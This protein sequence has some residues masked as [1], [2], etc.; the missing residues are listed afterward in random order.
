VDLKGAPTFDEEEKSPGT[1][2][3]LFH[4][5]LLKATEGTNR[6]AVKQQHNISSLHPSLTLTGRT[7]HA[8]SKAFVDHMRTA[9]SLLKKTLRR[10]I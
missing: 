2:V 9:G 4:K 10:D 1:T 3:I 7:M 8:G 6:D 5:V